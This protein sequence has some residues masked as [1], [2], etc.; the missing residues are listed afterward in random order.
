ML[1]IILSL[2]SLILFMVFSI[3]FFFK[4]KKLKTTYNPFNSVTYTKNS[5]IKKETLA[6]NIN[7]V[8]KNELESNEFID[9]FIISS[10]KHNTYC[11]CHFKNENSEN[12]G[13]ILQGFNEKKEVIFQTVVIE[14]S[15]LKT[16]PMIL[17]P[18]KPYDLN[19][20]VSDQATLK[21]NQ[22]NYQ[23]LLQGYLSLNKQ[24]SVV[25][26]LLLI[27]L[28][29]FMLFFLKY[30]YVNYY[31]NAINIF[32]GLLIIGFT[33]WLNYGFFSKYLLS[34]FHKRGNRYE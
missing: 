20:F 2:F 9:S 10:D 27:P 32:I 6:G 26:A 29:Y 34:L 15:S 14:A 30:P 23:N 1:W 8:Y 7:R 4:A 22:E 24:F 16:Y 28:G 17:L 21:E 3:V 31:L 12:Q 33:C 18:K 25:L 11:L 13:L 19:I 5:L